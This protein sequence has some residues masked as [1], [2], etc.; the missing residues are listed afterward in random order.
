MR[1]PSEHAEILKTVILSEDAPARVPH[2][3]TTVIL[4]E[5]APARVPHNSTTVI[6]SEDAPANP[7][8]RFWRR[9]LP[10]RIRVE[11]P[12][13]ASRMSQSEAFRPACSI[14]R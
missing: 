3:L 14:T 8:A 2:N 10:V 9:G 5:D 7:R 13:R 1:S 4:S 6:L 11:G 12:L